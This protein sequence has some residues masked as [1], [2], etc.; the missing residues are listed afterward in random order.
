MNSK[1]SFIIPSKYPNHSELLYAR[2]TFINDSIKSVLNY[3]IIV[4]FYLLSLLFSHEQREKNHKISTALN[5]L[6][7]PGT[8]KKIQ[9]KL[10]TTINTIK[11]YNA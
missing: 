2:A 10:T 5:E 1:H 7:D 3:I 6:F 8:F 9:S 4:K 11:T